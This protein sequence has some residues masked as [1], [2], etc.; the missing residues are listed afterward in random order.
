VGR[1]TFENNHISPRI[2]LSR[3]LK[4]F[5]ISIFNDEDVLFKKVSYIFCKDEYLLALNQQYLHH[6]RYTDVLTFTLSGPDQEIISEIYISVERV[7]ENS[8][9]LK[10][11]YSQELLRVMIHGVLHLCGYR[12][13]TPRQKTIMRAQEDY[14]L[15]RLPFHVE[16]F[17]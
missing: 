3:Q 5:L 8:A 13:T 1:I 4:S 10:S 9:K 17:T 6:D 15:S 7:M 11:N 16:R 12:D 2:S 14:Y